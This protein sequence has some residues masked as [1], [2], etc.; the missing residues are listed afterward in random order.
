M[1]SLLLKT[2]MNR[3]I[4]ECGYEKS[5]KMVCSIVRLMKMKHRDLDSRRARIVARE[6]LGE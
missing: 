6:L 4:K 2:R 1:S 3:I 5:P